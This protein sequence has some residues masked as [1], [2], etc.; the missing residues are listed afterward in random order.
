MSRNIEQSIEELRSF[1]NENVRAIQNDLPLRPLV[2]SG[3]RSKVSDDDNAIS[4]G[5]V[6][7]ESPEDD[8]IGTSKEEEIEMSDGIPEIV[9]S[10]STD[11]KSLAVNTGD[12]KAATAID[13]EVV[14]IEFQNCIPDKVYKELRENELIGATDVE[15]IEKDTVPEKMDDGASPKGTL[16][17][18]DEIEPIEKDVVTARGEEVKNSLGELVGWLALGVT[19]QPLVTPPRCRRFTTTWKAVRRALDACAASGPISSS[20]FKIRWCV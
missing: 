3:D 1:N 16:A 5:I 15:A 6:Q 20:K 9:E 8:L 7:T 17:G 19:M 4:T 18:G 10:L 14:E 2:S 12:V 13:T 11:D